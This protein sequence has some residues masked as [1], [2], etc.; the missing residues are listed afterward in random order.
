MTRKETF[1]QLPLW[2][3]DLRAHADPSVS[4]ILLGNKSDLD[5]PIST[6]PSGEEGPIKKGKR[7]VEKAEGEAFAKQEGLLF[8]ECSAKSGEG[9]N[10][11]RSL[12]PF[13]ELEERGFEHTS[14]HQA[15]DQTGS[16]FILSFTII[17]LTTQLLA[18]EILE[19][20]NQG[21]FEGSHPSSKSKVG[22]PPPFFAFF[23]KSLTGRSTVIRNK[24][25]FEH[26]RRS[27]KFDR[28]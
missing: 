10:E 26:P 13:F 11:V 27:N 18:R 3:K 15:F 24:T 7:E 2:L 1:L 28:N 16:F 21:L 8:L 4:I 20:I 6:D 9:V 5:P 22:V 12:P 19:K 23:F 25:F 17:M 14:F